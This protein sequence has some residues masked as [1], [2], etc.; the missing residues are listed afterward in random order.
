MYSVQISTKMKNNKGSGMLKC[1]I[2]IIN[3][4]ENH[5]LVGTGGRG[6]L[7]LYLFHTCAIVS[8]R[9]LRQNGKTKRFVPEIMLI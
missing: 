2:F 3:V 8:T 7:I 1:S 9:N 6:C 5:L 4:A